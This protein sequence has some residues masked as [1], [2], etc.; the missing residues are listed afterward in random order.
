MVRV[1]FPQ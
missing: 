1:L